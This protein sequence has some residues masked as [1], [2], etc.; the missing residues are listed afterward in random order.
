MH[1]EILRL[2]SKF[3]CAPQTAGKKKPS[4]LNEMFG[5]IDNLHIL[6][7]GLYLCISGY[8]NSLTGFI[9]VH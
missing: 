2:I 3:V 1:Q 7:W 5:N 9:R 8:A 4:I 6:M